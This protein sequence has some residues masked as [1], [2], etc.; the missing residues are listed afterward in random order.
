MCGWPV[1]GF[2]VHGL[3]HDQAAVDIEDT[4]AHINMLFQ[5]NLHI[6]GWLQEEDVGRVGDKDLQ[7]D[8]ELGS[9]AC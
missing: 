7:V 5:E 3:M 4:L 6:V 1:P 8:R 9:V 2:L